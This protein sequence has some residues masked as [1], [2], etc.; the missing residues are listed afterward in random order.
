MNPDHLWA[1]EPPPPEALTDEQR[2]AWGL[3]P[4]PD[5]PEEAPRFIEVEI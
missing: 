2:A 1:P 5:D 4:R 3:D